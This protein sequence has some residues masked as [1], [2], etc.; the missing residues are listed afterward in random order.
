MSLSVSLFFLHLPV[1]RSRREP[2]G[3][4]LRRTLRDFLD[5]FDFL[6]LDFL[7]RLLTHRR[8]STL[9]RRKPGRHRRRREAVRD[10]VRRLLVRRDL[11]RLFTHRRRSTFERRKPGRQRRDRERDRD[12]GICVGCVFT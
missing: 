3:Q 9:E 4:R 11:V 12:A 2:T 10:L 7:E 5:F 6:D 8:R 1:L